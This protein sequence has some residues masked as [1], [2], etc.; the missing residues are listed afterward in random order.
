MD[1]LAD[2]LGR[3]S[4]RILSQ[5][6]LSGSSRA[7]HSR[8]LEAES[9]ASPRLWQLFDLLEREVTVLGS[10]P[11]VRPIGDGQLVHYELQGLMHRFEMPLIAGPIRSNI[12]NLI[13][14]YPVHIGREIKLRHR[15]WATGSV[16]LGLNVPTPFSS[17]KIAK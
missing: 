12:L 16:E 2:V 15:R 5:F 1:D 7:I 17:I 10:N 6:Y 8:T 4:S 3:S 14:G 9:A 13:G 11:E